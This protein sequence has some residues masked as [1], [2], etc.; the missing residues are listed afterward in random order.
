METVHFFVGQE[1]DVTM[2]TVHLFVGQEKDVTMETVLLLEKEYKTF[3]Q[4]HGKKYIF[5][6][7]N[8]T[9]ILDVTGGNSNLTTLL[10]NKAC[11]A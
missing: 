3:K 5:F 11:L 2:E 10:R 9:W 4:N 6:V 7:G 1:K 8:R